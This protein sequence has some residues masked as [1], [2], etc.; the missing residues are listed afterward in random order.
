MILITS[1]SYM[2]VTNAIKAL[3]A[4]V[5]G[6]K[7]VSR[8]GI[9]SSPGINEPKKLKAKKKIQ[10]GAN[11][12]A[13]AM[14]KNHE[15]RASFANMLWFAAFK[16]TANIRTND[17]PAD[18]EY[19]HNRKFFVEIRLNMFQKATIGLLTSLFASFLRKGII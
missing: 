6:G 13:A 9:M 19:Y 8:L 16:A 4:V 15:F 17:F 2:G 1:G 3:S 5:S 11:K 18:F 10:T 14:Q 12:F 7:I